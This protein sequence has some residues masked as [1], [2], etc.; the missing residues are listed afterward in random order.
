M[1]ITVAN[2]NRRITGSKTT[3]RIERFLH[4]SLR[5][6]A[7]MVSR[8]GELDARMRAYR[9][10]NAC[11]FENTTLEPKPQVR[12]C[13]R[14]TTY[15]TNDYAAAAA[16]LILDIRLTETQR[17]NDPDLLR[18]PT[19]ISRALETQALPLGGIAHARTRRAR[20]MPPKGASGDMQHKTLI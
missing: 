13:T 9:L 5:Y 17:D 10:F 2:A 7:R 1:S 3:V 12:T 15:D 11:S 14:C 8:L 4:R 20:S 18:S 16:V 19:N 6:H